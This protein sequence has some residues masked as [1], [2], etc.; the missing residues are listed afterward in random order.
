MHLVPCKY[1]YFNKVITLGDVFEVRRDFS[2][3]ICKFIKVTRKGFN[4]LDL[5]TNRTI[6]TKRHIYATKMAGKEYPSSGVI[7]AKFQIPIY[8]HLKKI[9]CLEEKKA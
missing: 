8:L 3:S 4:F 7:R 6:L 5:A 9:K 2:Y 1:R